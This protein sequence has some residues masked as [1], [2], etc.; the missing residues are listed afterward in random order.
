MG[1]LAVL[2]VLV[3]VPLLLPFVAILLASFPVTDA[4]KEEIEPVDDPSLRSVSFEI[5]SRGKKPGKREAPNS[6]NVKIRI[7]ILE[8]GREGG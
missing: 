8:G 6:R 3:P 5:A 1:V 2:A 7:T 4:Q